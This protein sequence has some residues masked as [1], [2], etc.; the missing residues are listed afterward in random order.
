MTGD[1]FMTWYADCIF[2][3]DHFSTLG[4]EFK[5]HTKCQEKNWDDKSIRSSDL[6]TQ[7]TEL[8]VQKI[9]ESTLYK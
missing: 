8:Q 9:I 2:N 6:R 7:E 3:G 4:G 1:L 5:Y